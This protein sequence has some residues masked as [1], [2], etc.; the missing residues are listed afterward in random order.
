[1]SLPGKVC[2]LK[3]VR[4]IKVSFY[5]EHMELNSDV[6]LFDIAAQIFQHEFDH[7]Q[8]KLIDG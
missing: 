1:M 5:N 4:H 6:H 8:G 7:L 3:R 2:Q